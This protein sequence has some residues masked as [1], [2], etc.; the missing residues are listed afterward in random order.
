MPKFILKFM[1]SKLLQMT[2]SLVYKGNKKTICSHLGSGVQIITDAPI[3]NNGEG[4]AF[5]P[6]DL[7]AT[8]LA[9]CMLTLMAMKA[10]DMQIEL[11]GSKAEVTKIMYSDPRRIGEIHITFHFPELDELQLPKNREIL[12]RVAMHC[13]VYHSLHPD[14]IKKVQFIY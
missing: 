7:T 5:S 14:I 9:A 3:D 6:T 4:S 2:A 11:K 1:R 12:E 8:S 10:S 13:P